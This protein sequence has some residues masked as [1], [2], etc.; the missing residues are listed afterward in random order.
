MRQTTAASRGMTAEE[1][2]RFSSPHE[3]SEMRVR[4]VPG[5]A[6][7]TRATRS[8]NTR[9]RSRDSFSPELF[10]H[11]VPRKKE[12][13]GNAGCWLHPRALRAKRLHLYARKQ[14]QVQPEQPAF[15]AQWFYGLYVISS[16]RRA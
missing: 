10:D 13:A 8:S 12:G 3:R 11:H 7:L 15:P 6:A 9:L 5:I 4:P 1:V 2:I 16:V 14:R